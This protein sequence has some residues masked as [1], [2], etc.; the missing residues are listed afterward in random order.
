M[1]NKITYIKPKTK[2]QETIGDIMG[3]RELFDEFNTFQCPILEIPRKHSSVDE[4]YI[5]S[6]LAVSL[7]LKNQRIVL[8]KKIKEIK[9]VLDKIEVN[10]ERWEKK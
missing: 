10:K 2:K 3:V 9:T 4:S 8:N 5:Q 6:L 1:T 7:T